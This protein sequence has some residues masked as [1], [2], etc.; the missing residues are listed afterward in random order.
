MSEIPQEIWDQVVDFANEDG[1][2]SLKS[3]TL[4]CR[5]WLPHAR[6]LLFHDFTFPPL[7]HSRSNSGKLDKVP[8]TLHRINT[9]PITP[10]LST[11]VRRLRVGWPEW[12]KHADVHS[13]PLLPEILFSQFSFNNLTHIRVHAWRF[14]ASDIESMCDLLARQPRLEYLAFD[15]DCDLSPEI[16]LELYLAAVRHGKNL[17]TLSIPRL[18]RSMKGSNTIGVPRTHLDLPRLHALR[19]SLAE[20]H[21]LSLRLFNTSSLDR[22]VIGS[23]GLR[24]PSQFDCLEDILGQGGSSA[25]TIKDL[26]LEFDYLGDTIERENFKHFQRLVNVRHFT[27]KFMRDCNNLSR[28]ARTMIEFF[29]PFLPNLRAFTLD[30][31]G[32]GPTPSFFDQST[33][34]FLSSLP[35]TSNPHLETVDFSV[36]E[37]WAALVV[38]LLP[39]TQE[40]G[41]L[42]VRMGRESDPF[43]LD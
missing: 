10:S 40:R 15:D 22:L 8:L 23:G 26:I 36:K 4:V 11:V 12:W 27:I 32:L 14:F 39:K 16:F 34:L 9:S 2:N 38:K 41:L 42:N 19:F 29:L 21:L 25:S 17:H 3:C 28:H 30:L 35:D 43:G 18:E 13:R 7:L 1:S 37:E 20:R 31:L 6:T 24:L 5:A 33:D